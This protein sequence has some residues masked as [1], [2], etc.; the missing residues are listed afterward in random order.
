MIK[1]CTCNVAAAVSVR[2]TVKVYHS[3]NGDKH[4]DHIV[5]RART[6]D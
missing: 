1:V 4:F 3:V 2:V 6:S 5:G